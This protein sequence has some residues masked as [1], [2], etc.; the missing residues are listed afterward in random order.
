[1]EALVIKRKIRELC[2]LHLVGCM[3]AY[4]EVKDLAV[5]LIY[6]AAEQWALQTGWSLNVSNA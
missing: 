1:V 5:D 4:P 3:A 2:R 6:S